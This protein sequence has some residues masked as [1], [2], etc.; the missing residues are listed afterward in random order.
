MVGFAFVKVLNFSFIRVI[1]PDSEDNKSLLQWTNHLHIN[2]QCFSKLVYCVHPI[3]SMRPVL[4][5]L[6]NRNTKWIVMDMGLPILGNSEEHIF[7]ERSSY[8]VKDNFLEY[9]WPNQ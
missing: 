1:D 7:K 6:I 8:S 2:I 3:Y 9:V 5:L 4:L